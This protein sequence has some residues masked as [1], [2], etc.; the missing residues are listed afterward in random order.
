MKCVKA[1]KET[2][3][4]KVGDIVRVSDKEADTRVSTGYWGY[5]AKTEWKEYSRK[6]VEIEKSNEKPDLKLKRN[7]KKDKFDKKQRKIEK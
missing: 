4:S 3:T 2:K 5:V 7:Q 6:P 1:I